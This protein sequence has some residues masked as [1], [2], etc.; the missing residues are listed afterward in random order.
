MP[1]SLIL[2]HAT[3]LSLTL[4]LTQSLA[5][6][7][8]VGLIS[9]GHSAYFGAGAYTAAAVAT[10][11]FPRGCADSSAGS[12]LHSFFSRHLDSAEVFTILA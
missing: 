10:L 1:L 3:M 5:R 6:L 4:L 9:F 2:Y 7:W 8:N 12:S 11:I